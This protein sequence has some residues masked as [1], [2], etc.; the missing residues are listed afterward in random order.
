[1]KKHIAWL[2]LGLL[3]APCANA[4]SFG[5]LKEAR[6]VF[7][8]AMKAFQ[9][10]QITEGYGILKPYWPMP[11]VELE[12][13]ANTTNTQWPMVKQRFGTSIG[14]EFI[15]EEKAGNSLARFIYLQKFEHHAIRWI[16]R[17]YKPRDK[18]VI[19]GVSFDDQIEQ[20]FQ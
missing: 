20:L 3:I 15:L 7:E 8:Q 10:E 17:L 1:M 19:N 6:S 4:D 5:S 9:S 12:N 13:L 2:V 14:T 16:F 11:G 18:W